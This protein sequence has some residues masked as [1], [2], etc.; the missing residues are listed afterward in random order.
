MTAFASRT[1][2]ACVAA[3]ALLLAA[4]GGGSSP[5]NQPPMPVIASPAEGATFKAGDTITFN[6]SATDAEDGAL[7]ASGLTWWAVLHHDTHTHP[8]QPE[9]P[10]G[11]GTVTIPVRG[12]VSSNIWYRFHLRATDSAGQAV[13]VTRDVQPRKVQVTVA[14]QPAGLALTLD[15]QPITGPTAFTGVVGIERDL[16]A[17][18]Q[19]FNGRRYRFDTWSDGKPATHTISTPA[20]DT[21][22]TASFTDVGASTNQ[23]PTVTL[24]ASANGTVGAPMTVSATAADSDGTVAK[25]EFL[26]GATLLSTDTTAPYSF[27]WT[28][29]VAGVHALT[30]RATDN[31]GAATTSAVVNVTVAAAG[32][33]DTTPP[34]ATLTAPADFAS[35]LTGMLTL[36]ATATDNGAVAGVEFQVD[37]VIVGTEDTTAPYSASVD[38]SLYADGQHVVRARA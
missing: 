29:S 2:A 14:T 8:F 4:C 16:T 25:V 13:E 35:G 19:N 24:S 5:G 18:D 31:A 23:P 3:A 15:G 1:V 9:T 7:P 28:P 33:S 17:A 21:T 36:S 11:S 30:A 6:G 27:A 34:V 37:G 26:D 38:T 32:G 20:T 22:Y 10:G 12:E